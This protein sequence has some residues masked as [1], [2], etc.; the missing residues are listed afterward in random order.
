MKSR[1]FKDLA[2]QNSNV[3]TYDSH[4][5]IH[6]EVDLVTNK[7]GE[8]SMKSKDF[9]ELTKQISFDGSYDDQVYIYEAIDLYVT[10]KIRERVMQD[11]ENLVSELGFEMP[12]RTT[13]GWNGFCGLNRGEEDDAY[14]ALN[15]WMLKRIRSIKKQ[16][17]NFL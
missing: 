8:H 3:Y 4:A 7:I 12:K 10:N 9:R 14:D 17:K 13:E 6:E 11:A 16:V 5:Y 1:D 15:V 2:K